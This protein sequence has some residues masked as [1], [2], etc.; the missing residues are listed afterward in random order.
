MEI[1]IGS[2]NIGIAMA[3]PYGLVVPII[4]NVQSLSILEVSSMSPLNYGLHCVS[5]YVY[6]SW[7]VCM[8]FMIWRTISRLHVELYDSKIFTIISTYSGE[9]MTYAFI[10]YMF[11]VCR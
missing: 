1:V 3:T 6:T 10:T 9:R 8:R 7:F 2:H 5:E 4:K 11:H